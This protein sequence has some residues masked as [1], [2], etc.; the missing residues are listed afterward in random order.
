MLYNLVCWCSNVLSS[1]EANGYG[2]YL[3]TI[4]LLYALQCL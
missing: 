3:L 1:M 2:D 4:V